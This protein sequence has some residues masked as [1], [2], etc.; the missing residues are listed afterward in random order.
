MTYRIGVRGCQHLGY[1][2]KRLLRVNASGRNQRAVDGH[3]AHRLTM[4]AMLAEGVDGIVDG[5]DLFHVSRPL[6]GDV[7][8]AI[9]VD[10]MRLDASA[11]PWL[12]ANSGNH[13]ADTGA[14]MSA[15]AT[16]HRPS[17]DA[18]C[19]FP[20][21][22]DGKGPHPGYYEIHHPAGGPPL[23]FV[24]HYGLDPAIP[25]RLGVTIHPAP[26]DD[27]DVSLLFCHGV[28]TGDARLRIASER[29]GAQRL[30]PESWVAEFPAGAL[31]SDF[32]SLGPVPTTPGTVWYTGSAVRRGFSDTPGARGWL[33]TTIND[34]GVVTIEPQAV[35]QRPQHD[36]GPV[37]AN[38]LAVASIDDIVLDM[39][40]NSDWHDPESETLTGDGGHLLRMKIT[41]TTT[42]QRAAISRLRAGWTR[43]AQGALQLL[44]DCPADRD[45]QP[46]RD[47]ESPT[48]VGVRHGT[49]ADDLLVRAQARTGRVGALLEPAPELNAER[50]LGQARALLAAHEDGV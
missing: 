4:E 23:H 2:D 20:G 26:R 7:E 31:L 24:S 44:V 21:S 37:D 36:L 11:R 14:G 33:L 46:E 40:G 39:L 48:P 16:V 27:D 42:A 49:L 3:V 32:H 30:I 5:G 15:V 29:H 50:A 6:P 9:S 38:G 25:D 28:F 41:G 45:N 47:G 10:D 18:R 17:L 43:Q 34:A 22:R 1:A 8:H 19:V 35:W 12:V 13:D